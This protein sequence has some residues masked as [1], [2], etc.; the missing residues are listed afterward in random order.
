MGMNIK[1]DKEIG[2]IHLTT[3][4]GVGIPFIVLLYLLGCGLEWWTFSYW[5]GLLAVLLDII[6]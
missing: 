6:F 5:K 4:I 1:R 2:K 3:S